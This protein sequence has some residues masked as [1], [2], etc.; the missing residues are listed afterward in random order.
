MVAALPTVQTPT[1]SDLLVRSAQRD[2][3]AFC[4]LYAAIG[5]RLKGYVHRMCKDNGLAEELTQEVLLTVWRR[6]E[7]F[8]PKRAKA[9]T[10]IF[11]I[12]R[13]RAIDRIR[14]RKIVE[15]DARDPHFVPTP[16]KMSDL[17]VEE[18]QVADRVHDAIEKLP[19]AQREVV[20]QAFFEARSYAEIAESVGVPLGTVKSRARLA[21]QRLRTL[22]GGDP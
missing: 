4:E 6:A 18:R 5:P 12:A 21:F 22:L 8:D 13:N 1:L 16:P 14:H 7:R 17:L 11:T 15:A 19:E 10:W 9:E 2:K 20:T 3:A